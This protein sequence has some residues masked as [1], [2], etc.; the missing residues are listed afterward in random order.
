MNRTLIT[1]LAIA[2]A[3]G[4]QSPEEKQ[5]PYGLE[6][7]SSTKAYENTVLENPDKK[8]FDIANE[9]PSIALDIR[10]ATTNNF[11]GQVMYPQARAFARKP[12]VEALKNVQA[13]LNAM[14]LGLKI[15]DAYRP[16]ATTLKFYE[17]HPDTNYVAAP[18]K[19]SRHNRGCAI[20]LTIIELQS[21]VELE[22]P[23]PYDD[24]TEKAWHNYSELSEEALK[25][26]ALLREV[27]TRH[28]FEIFDS[29]WWHYDFGGWK[30]YELMDLS[31]EELSN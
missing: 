25:N 26:R 28:G 23:T 2:F 13:E 3:F 21:G 27:M 16:Y 19:G 30:A 12:V 20:D 15:F 5:N 14:G 18:W 24:F 11:T 10:Y 7:I 17:V 9:I 8:M 4:C 22:M 29:E 31:F 1:T 6:I